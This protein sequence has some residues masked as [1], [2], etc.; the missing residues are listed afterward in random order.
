MWF[1]RIISSSIG[2]KMIMALSGLMLLLFLC[3]HAAGNATIYMSRAV[4]QGYADE[5]HSHPLI[6]IVFSTGIFLVF[7]IH[8]SFGLLLFLQNRQAGASRYVVPARV[9][10]NSL[11]S[12][13]MPYT[14]LF[15]LLFVLVHVSGFAFG[16]AGEMISETVKRLLGH[17]FYGLFYLVAFAALALHLSHG[18]WSMLQTFGTNHP[19]Y[20]ALIGKLTYI[21]PLFFLLLF[22]GIVLYFMTGMGASF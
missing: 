6:V 12:K 17:F 2:K 21:V 11:A 5:L 16:P 19:Q 14:G 3:S 4:F 7:L 1:V 13:T 9:V 18:F 15:I 20:N 10:T 22:G 8:I